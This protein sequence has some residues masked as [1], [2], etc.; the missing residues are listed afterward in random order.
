MRRLFERRADALIIILPPDLGDDLRP[1]LDAGIPVLA[2]FSRAS[3]SEHIPML[4]VDE[5]HAIAQA[6]T[7]LAALGHRRVLY[8]ATSQGVRSARVVALRRE[9]QRA[10]IDVQV[11]AIP[12]DQSLPAIRAASRSSGY[13][14]T[15]RQSSPITRFS[16]L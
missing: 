3:G 12:Y 15:S 10:T 13:Q 9:A 1:Y 7:R 6:I 2:L 11:A 16:A 5:G 14:A 8:V 4:Q